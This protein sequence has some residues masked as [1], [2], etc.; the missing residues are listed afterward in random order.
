MMK[1]RPL[2]RL[3]FMVLYLYWNSSQPMTPDAWLSLVKQQRAIAVIRAPDLN[4]GIAMARAVADGGMRLIEITWNSH[5]PAALV[6]H[7]RQALPECCIGAGTILSVQEAQDAIAAG[8]TFCISPHTDLD[9]IQYC[10][11]YQVAVVPG[12]LTPNEILKAWQAGATAVKVFPIN[13]MGGAA[14]IRSLQ[15]P[16]GH[17]PLLPTGGVT[18]DNAHHLIRA[19]ATGVGLSSSL[20]KQAMVTNGQWQAVTQLAR[21]LLQSLRDDSPGPGDGPE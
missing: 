19:G 3:F 4:Q 9:V 20:F 1:R 21:A 6:S 17:I 2:G 18:L 11:E 10:R 5:E 13:T 14:Y 15:G 12:V 8:A 7:L 16:I